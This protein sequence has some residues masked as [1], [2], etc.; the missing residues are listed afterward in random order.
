MD[1][2]EVKVKY[3]KT[4]KVEIERKTKNRGNYDFAVPITQNKIWIE[5]IPPDTNEYEPSGRS[6]VKNSANPKDLDTI[7][8]VMKKQACTE[9]AAALAA[10]WNTVEFVRAGGNIAIT[11]GFPQ[12][13]A[14]DNCATAFKAVWDDEDLISE[15]KEL[16]L[17]E[18]LR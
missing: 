4:G 16:K 9:P 11:V 12:A 18:W 6:R 8:L 3:S 14:K 7:G 2:V 17:T 1:N 5:Y 13:L 15:L 10:A